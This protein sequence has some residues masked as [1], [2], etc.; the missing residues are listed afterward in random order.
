MLGIIIFNGCGRLAERETIAKSSVKWQL[1]V[2]RLFMIIIV[3]LW[4][5]AVKH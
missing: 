5:V 2:L 3:A 1:S 4:T